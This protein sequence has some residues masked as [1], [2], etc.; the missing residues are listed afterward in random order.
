MLN[1]SLSSLCSSLDTSFHARKSKAKK[2]KQQKKKEQ[3]DKTEE[4]RKKEQE[5]VRKEQTIKNLL[6]SLRSNINS[7]PQKPP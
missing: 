3:A 1:Q 7:S 2:K 6:K 5:K 4:E